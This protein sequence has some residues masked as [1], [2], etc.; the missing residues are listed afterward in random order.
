MLIATS[1]REGEVRL[2]DFEKGNFVCKLRSTGK[3]VLAMEFLDPYP[4]L[5][6]T[7]ANG[8]L[9]VHLVRPHKLET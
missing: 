4:L 7:D 8:S 5:V 9:C 2:W 6:T 1:T 3:E